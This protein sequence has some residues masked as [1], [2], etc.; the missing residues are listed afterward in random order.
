VLFYLFMH[1]FVSRLFSWI[2]ICIYNIDFYCDNDAKFERFSEKEF[3][4]RIFQHAPPLRPHLKRFEDLYSRFLKYLNKVPVYG[5][6]LLNEA[7][8][9]CIM[10]RSFKGHSWSF[11][12]GKVNLIYQKNI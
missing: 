3:C 9:K 4:L 1:F 6:I 11:P 10:V 7:L 12:R 5:C 2:I 8:N